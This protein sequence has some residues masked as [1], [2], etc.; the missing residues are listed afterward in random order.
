MSRSVL[1]CD[2][3]PLLLQ[4]LVDLLRGAGGF[5]ILDST[6]SGHRALSQIR[7]LRPDIAVLDVSMPDIGGLDI[8]RAVHTERL[9]VRV[10]FLTATI[11]GKKVAEAL[12]YG[13]WGLLTKDYA[14]EHFLECLET[15]AAGERWLPK[16][17]LEKVELEED[18][19]VSARLATLTLR[20]LEISRLVCR[21]LSNRAIA[22]EL[23]SAEGTVSIH[24]G[25][26]YRKLDI[27]SRTMLAS[28]LV[29]HHM[30]TD[31]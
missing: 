24:L 29:Q 18:D 22:A 27:S 13:I 21:G 23:G 4:G 14:T 31:D 9:G 20:E 6:T 3:H 1:L 25:N 2:D 7:K 11:P 28:L 19:D 17:L 12:S 30:L 10:V 15:V 16:S 26:I 5:D 8:L